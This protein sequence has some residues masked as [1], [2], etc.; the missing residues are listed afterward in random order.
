MAT[1]VYINLIMKITMLKWLISFIRERWNSLF[2]FGS[3][4]FKKKADS[5]VN[6]IDIAFIIN[7]IHNIYLNTSVSADN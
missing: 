4:I 6:V 2:N 7:K 1:I 3:F 5:I